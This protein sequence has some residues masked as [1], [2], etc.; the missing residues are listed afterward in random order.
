MSEVVSAGAAAVGV[1]ACVAVAGLA[2]AAGYAVYKGLVWLSEQAKGE[3][4]RLEKEL[5]KPV[6]YSTTTEARK[7]FKKQFA[8]FKLEAQRSPL[9]KADADRVASLLAL[10]ASP[11]GLFLKSEEWQQ[12][13]QPE[14]PNH[15]L[16]QMLGRAGKRFS[17]ANACCVAR[18]I[19]EG[20]KEAGFTKDGTQHVVNGKKVMVMKDELGRALVAEINPADDGAGI[21]LDLTGFGDGSCHGVMDRVLSGVTQ[22]GVRIDGLRRR[23]HYR[24]EGVVVPATDPTGKQGGTQTRAYPDQERREAEARRLRQQKISKTKV[25]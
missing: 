1:G 25:S 19:V 16:P 14:T 8:L 7:Q 4:E 22:R 2:L 13:V 24:R 3:M 11:F 5:A 21:K 10:K 23:S 6:S 20:A 15:L 12:L 9:L 17:E 18:S